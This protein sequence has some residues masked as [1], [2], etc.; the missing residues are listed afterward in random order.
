M[1]THAIAFTIGAV[2]ALGAGYLYTSGELSDLRERAREYRANLERAEERTGRLES[3]LAD[4][5]RDVAELEEQL[6]ESRAELERVRESH[7]AL[8]AALERGFEDIDDLESAIDA[9]AKHSRELARGVD[10]IEAV[11][12]A[13][14]ERGRAADP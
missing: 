2:V 5:A 6:D 8:R 13:V 7:R 12:R 3:E 11:V 14:R 1:Q 4:A 9:S 10:S